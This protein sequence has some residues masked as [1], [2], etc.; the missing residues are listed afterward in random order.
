MFF[1]GK[2]TRKSKT[3]IV[4]ATYEKKSYF[5][6]INFSQWIKSFLINI[7]FFHHNK[8]ERKYYQTVKN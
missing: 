1:L 2:K 5:L 4:L 8:E 3:P 7:P 6:I